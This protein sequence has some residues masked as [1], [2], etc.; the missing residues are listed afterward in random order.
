M[1]GTLPVAPVPGPTHRTR[2]GAETTV[3]IVLAVVTA[4]T[5]FA[6]LVGGG[7]LVWAQAALRDDGGYYS[8]NGL[9]A[10]SA[11]HA[12]V[13]DDL[14]LQY[15]G[16]IGGVRP[17][18]GLDFRIAAE[19]TGPVF[20]GIGPRDQV[21]RYLAGVARDRVTDLETRTRSVDLVPSAGT[22]TPAPPAAQTFWV[23]SA[24]GPGE[25]H[26]DW[27]AR[28]GEWS[29]VVMNADGSAGVDV[30]ASGGVAVGILTPL[31]I[32]LL[33]GGV[34]FL[35]LTLVLVPWPRGSADRQRRPDDGPA[36]G[37]LREP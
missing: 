37:A 10:A 14:G 13:V 4:L 8:A 6:L 2:S 21:V 32:G 17:P 20:V 25:Q 11:G 26:V 18:G 36:P 5:A 3:R 15:L 30:T 33:V 27:A 16:V 29:V 35:G 19:G 22:R 28:S 24:Q 1:T 34:L 23:A 7:A 31:G 9:R 12:L